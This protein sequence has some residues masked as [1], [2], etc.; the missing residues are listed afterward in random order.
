LCVTGYGQ[1]TVRLHHS[2]GNGTRPLFALPD[3]VFHILAFMELFHGHPLHFGVVKEHLIPLPFDK[4]ET[5]IRNQLLDRTLW[6]CCPP[7]KQIVK[8]GQTELL[9]A[10]QTISPKIWEQK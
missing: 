4:P 8:R 1:A 7:T 9:L 10:K 3:L 5:S 6:H 2:D